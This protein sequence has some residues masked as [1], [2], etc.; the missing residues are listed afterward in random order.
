MEKRCLDKSNGNQSRLGSFVYFLKNST[1]G[2][3]FSI[4]EGVVPNN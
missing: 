1:K 2:E 4:Y 3:K